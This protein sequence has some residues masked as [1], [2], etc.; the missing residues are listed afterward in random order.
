MLVLVPPSFGWQS[1]RTVSACGLKNLSH[2]LLNKRFCIRTGSSA[3]FTAERNRNDDGKCDYIMYWN[4]KICVLQTLTKSFCNSCSLNPIAE[5]STTCL[6]LDSS[7]VTC[8]IFNSFVFAL[9][10][11]LQLENLVFPW[12]CSSGPPWTMMKW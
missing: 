9:N 10:R 1:W 11:H 6:P 8:I 12:P 5:S 7:A 3:S 2:K 4:L